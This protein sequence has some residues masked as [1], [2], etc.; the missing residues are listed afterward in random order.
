MEVP[1]IG[2]YVHTRIMANNGSLQELMSINMSDLYG[3]GSSSYDSMVP[4]DRSLN[5]GPQHDASIPVFCE[6]CNAPLIIKQSVGLPTITFTAGYDSQSERSESQTIGVC[7]DCYILIQR[8]CGMEPVQEWIDALKKRERNLNVQRALPRITF[9][10]EGDK[11]DKRLADAD[12]T[13]S[14]KSSQD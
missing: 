3:L 9:D 12:G 6:R 4:R 2:P 8:A 14:G 10:P 5:T 7:S 11:F 1:G 13:V